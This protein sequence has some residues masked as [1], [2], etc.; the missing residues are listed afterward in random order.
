MSASLTSALVVSGLI[1]SLP[2]RYAVVI[3]Y[4]EPH[5]AGRTKLRYADD[6]AARFFELVSPGAEQAYLLTSFDKRSAEV[7]QGL[8]KKTSAPTLSVLKRV[9]G[10][11]KSAFAKD[12]AAGISSEL[13][14]YYAGHGDVDDGEG[15]VNLADGYLRGS[16]FRAMLKTELRADTVHVVIDACKSYYFVAG[17]G[18]GGIRAPEKR[19]FAGPERIEGVGYVLSTSSDAD[20]HEWSALSGG[21][22]SHEVRSALVGGADADGDN[23]VDYDELAAFIAVANELVPVPRYRPDVYV[24]PPPGHRRTAIFRHAPLPTTRWLELP[25][26]HG[27]KVSITDHRGLRYADVNKTST[28]RLRVALSPRSSYDIIWRDKRFHVGTGTATVSLVSLPPDSEYVASRGAPHQAFEHL[29]EAPFSKD[30]VRGFQLAP[31]RV[32]SREVLTQQVVVAPADTNPIWLEAG[33][34]GSGAALLIGGTA[35]GIVSANVRA[36]LDPNTSQVERQRTADRARAY[37]I[38]SGVALGV[39]LAT[40]GVA[41]YLYLSE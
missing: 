24:R 7:F 23:H 12:R 6:D 34:L 21:I 26:G 39:G 20:A 11:L 35:L 36:G 32:I 4:N 27:G 38:G 37:M 13:Y 9:A 17:R 5:T 31:V 29:F 18:P 10:A 8:F 1:A 16:A 14:F 40:L 30:I 28:E 25:K 3:G 15:F 22:F 33:L 19:N 2:H 41:L